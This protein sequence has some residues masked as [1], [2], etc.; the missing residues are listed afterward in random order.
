[1]K[2]SATLVRVASQQKIKFKFKYLNGLR[3]LF[4]VVTRV[5][6]CLVCPRA[7]ISSLTSLPPTSLSL[8]SSVAVYLN[9]LLRSPVWGVSAPFR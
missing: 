8:L 3:P 1:M 9:E 7:R 5:A 6:P 4:A 2:G